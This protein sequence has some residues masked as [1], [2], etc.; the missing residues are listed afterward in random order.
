MHYENSAFTS[1]YCKPTVLVKADPSYEIRPVFKRKFSPQ[2]IK[3]INKLYGCQTN[4]LP[5]EGEYSIERPL[6]LLLSVT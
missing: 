3:K 6:V 4:D 5:P 2:D 1:G